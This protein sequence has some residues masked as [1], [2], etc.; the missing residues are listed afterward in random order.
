MKPEDV[1]VIE[2]V[3]EG[4]VFGLLTCLFYASISN[5]REVKR[6]NREEREG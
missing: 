2:L 1:Q 6:R 4:W 5:Y 3:F